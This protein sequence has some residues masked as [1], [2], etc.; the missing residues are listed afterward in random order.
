MTP[1]QLFLLAYRFRSCNEKCLSV[2]ACALFLLLVI[3][4]TQKEYY[5]LHRP[6]YSSVYNPFVYCFTDTSI[7]RF[8]EKIVGGENEF[9][10]M[11]HVAE[12]FREQHP[13]DFDLLCKV[14]AAYETV[15]YHR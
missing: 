8:D 1:L 15:H 5:N 3:I 12:T 14:P 7:P 11:F 2:S 9:L 4:N 13:E 10:D 6:I